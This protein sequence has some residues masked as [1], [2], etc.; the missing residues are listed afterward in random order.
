LI[1]ADT[2]ASAACVGRRWWSWAGTATD[3]PELWDAARRLCERCPSRAA[4]VTLALTLKAP[5][6]LWGGVRINAS[7]TVRSD[8]EIERQRLREALADVS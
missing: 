7:S 2:F 8:V 4:C 6:G 3:Q 1:P 5:T